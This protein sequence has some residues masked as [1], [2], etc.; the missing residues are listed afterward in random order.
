[1]NNKI[2]FL[3]ILLST[4]LFA[5]NSKHYQEIIKS[6]NEHYTFQMKNIQSRLKKDSNGYIDIY[7]LYD[8]S[9]YMQNAIIYADETKNID[10]IKKLLKLVLLPLSSNI[11]THNKWL[12]NGHKSN[13]RHIGKEIKLCL[14]KYFVLLTRTLSAAKKYNIK[15]NLSEVKLK[16]ISDHIDSWINKG[17][18]K[19]R[20]IDKDLYVVQAI[21]QFHHYMKESNQ[22]IINIKKWELFAQGYMKDT[23]TPKWEK[24]SCSYNKKRYF[25]LALDRIGWVNHPDFRYAGLGKDYLDKTDT[26]IDNNSKNMFDKDGIVKHKLKKNLLTKVAQ[27][28]SH[29]RRYNFFFETILRYGKPFNIYISNKILQGWANN[30]AYRVCSGT[31]ANPYFTIYSDGVDGWYRVNYSKR[32]SYGL[33][34]GE[35]DIHFVAS[36]YGMMGIYNSKIY[37]WMNTWVMIHGLEG[38]NGGYKLAYFTSVDINI[39]QNIIQE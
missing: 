16:I 21:L 13:K 36:S 33:S 11:I 37:E 14:S 3:Y 5:N 34:P 27:D 2:I 22:T 7:A 39:T 30:L 9:T 17:Y 6:F 8:M 19:K 26:L 24:V 1:M 23:I 35:L 25:C 15:F 31:L 10:M 28:I 38:Y 29:A 4:S 18:S 20:V 32:K 12:H